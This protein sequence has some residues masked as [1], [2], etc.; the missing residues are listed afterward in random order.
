MLNTQTDVSDHQC[1]LL[2]ERTQSCSPISTPLIKVY[3][4]L[5]GSFL[6]RFPEGAFYC[7]SPTDLFTHTE[8]HSQDNMGQST[9][10][11]THFICEKETGQGATS[12]SVQQHFEIITHGATPSQ[13]VEELDFKPN[14]RVRRFS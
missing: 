13:L 6:L 9:A 5:P 11:L 2:N 8:N 12:T 3:T 14:T 10:V 4:F 7:H 1:L